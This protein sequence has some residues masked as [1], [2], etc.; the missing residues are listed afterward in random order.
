[1]FETIWGHKQLNNR[2]MIRRWG[3]GGDK[4]PYKDDVWEEKRGG[5]EQVCDYKAGV[6]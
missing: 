6:W 4:W 2:V 5:F 1:M 3:P